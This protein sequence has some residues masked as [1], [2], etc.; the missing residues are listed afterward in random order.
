MRPDPRYMHDKALKNKAAALEHKSCWEGGVGDPESGAPLDRRMTSWETKEIKRW[1][2]AEARGREAKLSTQQPAGKRETT[3][4]AAKATATVMATR[5]A[6]LPML[7]DLVTTITM[8][9][10]NDH[11]VGDAV[12]GA[13][14]SWHLK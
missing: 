4:V 5:K 3:A 8:T 12:V 2:K 6:S 10:V 9:T 14:G 11:V 1:M 13:R 7:R